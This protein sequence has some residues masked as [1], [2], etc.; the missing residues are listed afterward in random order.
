MGKK[1]RGKENKKNLRPIPT[2]GGEEKEEA[3]NKRPVRKG[4]K[5]DFS[6][7]LRL[8]RL[9]GRP[10][11]FLLHTCTFI[12][13]LQPA[14]GLSFIRPAGRGPSLDSKRRGSK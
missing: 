4:P 14:M 6:L 1:E 13:V 8:L 7:L 12:V 2:L 3:E 11:S 9:Y 5:R 10:L